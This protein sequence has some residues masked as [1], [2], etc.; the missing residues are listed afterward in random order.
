MENFIFYSPTEIL[1]GKNQIQH[2]ASKIENKRVLLAYGSESIKNLGLYKQIIDIFKNNKIFY[3]ELNG[4]KPNPK[5]SSVREGIELCRK[6]DLDFILAAGGGSVI[7][8]SKA[9][10]LGYFYKGDAWE[11]FNLSFAEKEEKLNKALPLACILTLSAT[12]T[13]MN[14]NAVVSNE[15]TKEKIPIYAPCVK[16]RFSILDPTYTFSVPQNQ[17]KAGVVDILSHIFEQYF[18][19]TKG[20]YVQDNLAFALIKTCMKYGQIACDNPRNYEAR[21]NL[22]WSSTLALNGLLSCG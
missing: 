10:A 22:M 4:I 6:Y 17:T 13:E 2:L 19:P 8:C 9:I 1:F 7:D 15:E 21:A 11:M 12:G 14:A 18:S 3:K 16:P 5:I 20:A